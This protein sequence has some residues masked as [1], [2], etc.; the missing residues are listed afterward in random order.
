[1]LRFNTR[2]GDERYAV[3]SVGNGHGV[4]E[5]LW[6]EDRADLKPLHPKGKNRLASSIRSW[7]GLSR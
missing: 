1:F 3:I 5:I 2:A 7:R 6:H 4:A